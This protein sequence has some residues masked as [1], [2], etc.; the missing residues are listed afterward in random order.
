MEE[1][2]L[3]LALDAYDSVISLN[4]KHHD[5]I[6]GIAQIQLTNLD[7]INGFKNYEIRWNIK[8]FEYRHNSIKKLSHSKTIIIISHNT[9]NLEFCDNIYELKEKKLIKK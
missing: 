4:P 6:H 5:S 3:D 2:E 9:K 1:D 8:G 7:Y